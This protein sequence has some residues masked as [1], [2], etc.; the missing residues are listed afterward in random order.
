MKVD[1]VV[2]FHVAPLISFDRVVEVVVVSLSALLAVSAAD[3]VLAG[4]DSG[5]LRPFR[6]V[7]LFVEL[8]Q[9]SV[10]LTYGKST[11]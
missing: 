5:D 8:L 2:F 7:E 3:I 10:L 4:H 11:S 6:D 9:H 1:E